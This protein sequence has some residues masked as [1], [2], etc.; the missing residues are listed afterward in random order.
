[1]FVPADAALP[2]GA[3][4]G[5]RIWA[6]ANVDGT[7][8][9]RG[10][11]GVLS[12][13]GLLIAVSS[14]VVGNAASVFP[15]A[16]HRLRE[17]VRTDDAPALQEVAERMRECLGT[18]GADLAGLVMADLPQDGD[19]RWL[20]EFICDGVPYRIIADAAGLILRARQ[21]DGGA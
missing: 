6:R 13:E 12:L 15:A 1:V 7:P 18:S 21:Y 5:L 8:D 14:G 2:R 17:R 9:T 19:R 11:D 3:R 16:A 20:G 10:I 4:D